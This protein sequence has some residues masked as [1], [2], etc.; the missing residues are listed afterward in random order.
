MQITIKQ[1]KQL[2]R[3]TVED[4]MKEE[5][6]DECGMDDDQEGGPLRRHDREMGDRMHDR[7]MGHRMHDREMEDAYLEEYLA[8]AKKEKDKKVKSQQKNCQLL[9]LKLKK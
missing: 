1:L 5:T 7:E 8:E 3:E 9:L 2:I 4:K 6:V